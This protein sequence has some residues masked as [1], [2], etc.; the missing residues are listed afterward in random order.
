MK[1]AFFVPGVPQSKGS[2]MALP[3]GGKSGSRHVVLVEAGTRRTRPIKAAWYSKVAACA[4]EAGHGQGKGLRIDSAVSVKAVFR[5]P[6]PKSRLRG[7]RAITPGDPHLAPCDLD[8]ILRGVGDALT[9]SGVI[10][11]DRLITE[12]HARKIYCEA[13]DE[14]AE[15][16]LTW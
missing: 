9:R 8:K 13:G 3:M 16:L 4:L 2:H 12:W 14:G 6:I 7:K 5:F 10:A 11:D 1:L 15:V